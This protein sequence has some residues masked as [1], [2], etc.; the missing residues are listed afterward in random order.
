MS[1]VSQRKRIYKAKLIRYLQDYKN[2]I[3]VTAQH[4]GSHQLQLVRQELRGRAVVLMGKN[5]MIRMVLREFVETNPSFEKFIPLV[6]GNCGFVFTNEDVKVIRDVIT[7][8]RIQAT[9]RPGV[10]APNDVTV[11]AGPTGL[12]P[13]QTSFF[14][15][16]NIATKIFKGQIEITTKVYLIK[17]GDKVGNSECALLNKLDIKPFEYGLEVAS[18]FSEGAA[19]SPDVLDLTANDLVKK[20]FSAVRVTAAL[21]LR[22]GIPNIASIPHSFSN[23]FRKLLSVSVQSDY[24]FEAAASFKEYFADPAA[25]KLAHGGVEEPVDA[26]GE[27]QEE[28]EQEPEED[29]AESSEGGVCGMFGSDSDSDSD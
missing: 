24:T 6:R 8:N 23:A 19:F 16:L 4:V 10:F 2:I 22:I 12:D 3:V 9:A 20:F 13:G 15:A 28:K 25:Y 21:G 5:T 14:Q 17:K 7:S 1:Q 18:I 29:D 11:P 27:K 26:A